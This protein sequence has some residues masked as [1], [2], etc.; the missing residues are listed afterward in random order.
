MLYNVGVRLLSNSKLK[1]WHLLFFLVPTAVW[2]S[3]F[4]VQARGGYYYSDSSVLRKIYHNGGGE[5]EVEGSKYVYDNLSIWLN[6]NYFPRHGHSL[7]FHNGTTVKVFPISLGLKYAFRIM[8][9]TY[10]Y[11]GIGGSYTWVQTND[12]S[13]FVKQDLTGRGWGVVGK[14]GIF[15]TLG[16]GW[17]LD[18]FADYYYCKASVHHLSG[19]QRHSPNVGGVRSGLGLGIFF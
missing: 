5:F 4:T 17:F 6:F 1:Y 3:C 8:H 16:S 15:F 19:L 10:F 13:R 14:S 12:H 18:L 2:S 11:L 9:C 7:G